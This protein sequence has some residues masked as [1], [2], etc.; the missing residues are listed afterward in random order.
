MTMNNP[1]YASMATAKRGAQRK[2]ITNPAFIELD[3]GKIELRDMDHPLY[4]GA[5]RERSTVK[6]A[7][8]LVWDI[9]KAGIEANKRR[10]DI[11]AECVAQG[12]NINTAKTQYQL[13]RQAA[14][15]SK[16]RAA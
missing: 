14:G 15:L 12:V 2:G 4:N 6:G 13:Y 9:A 8:A 3:N 5:N 10:K 1:T 7:V 16:A 11:L